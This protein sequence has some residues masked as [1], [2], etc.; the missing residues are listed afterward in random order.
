MVGCIQIYTGNGKGKTTA[1]LG[2]ALRAA[3]AGM[4]V[5]I[6]QFVKGLPYSEFGILSRLEDRITLRQYG[7][8]CFIERN[9]TDQDK[10]LALGGLEEMERIVKTGNYD[11]VIFDEATIAIYYQ[12]FRTDD[13]LRIIEARPDHVEI[14][15]TGRYADES[16]IKQADLVTEMVEVKH[17]YSKGQQARIG[18]EK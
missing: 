6:G 11:L 4:R 7:R 8:D 1:A 3:G 5:F 16:L 2:L 18:I 10:A 15:I 12:L 14:V 17:Y 9:P 13:L